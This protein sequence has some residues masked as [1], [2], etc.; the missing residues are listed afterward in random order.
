MGITSSI[1]K[2]FGNTPDRPD[3]TQNLNTAE[4]YARA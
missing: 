4:A 3:R 1:G 2:T